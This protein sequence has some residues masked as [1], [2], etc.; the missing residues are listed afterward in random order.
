MRGPRTAPPL[1]LDAWH[2]SAAGHDE[3]ALSLFS[4]R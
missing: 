3:R 1:V 2:P 4:T